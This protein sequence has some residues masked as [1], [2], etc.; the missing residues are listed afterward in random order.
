MWFWQNKK[1]DLPTLLTMMQAADEV[2]STERIEILKTELLELAQEAKTVIAK[3]DPSGKRVRVLDP[4]YCPDKGADKDEWF[5]VGDLH[6]DFRSLSRILLKIYLRPGIDPGRVKI[7]FLGDYID[8]GARPLEVLKLLLRL[9]VEWPDH[10]WLL[11][12]NHECLAVGADG[13]VRA[14]VEPHDTVDFWKE[15]FG[16]EVFKALAQLFDVLPTALV[17]PLRPPGRQN[18]LD[19]EKILY[20]HGGIPRTEYL[21][22]PLEAPECQ[23]G[24]LWSDPEL[25]KEDV[26]NGPRKRFSFARKD[27][28]KFMAHHHIAL[29]V[30]GHEWRK[31]GFDLHEEL[32]GA[33]HRI[34]TIF[35][36]GGR[37][38]EDS[39]YASDI[40]VPRFLSMQPVKLPNLPISV[41]EVYRDDLSVSGSLCYQDVK[42]FEQI[43]SGLESKLAEYGG[44][45]FNLS[46]PTLS[47][48]A[49]SEDASNKHD[50]GD[51]QVRL[52][53]KNNAP[54]DQFS[55]TVHINQYRDEDTIAMGADFDM[56]N[57][58]SSILDKVSKAYPI[59][60]K[61]PQ[62]Y[63][64]DR[65]EHDHA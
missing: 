11:K 3:Q 55:Y 63:F 12:G 19:V 45:T 38:N 31:D 5:V 52:I 9:K 17:Q 24:F 39:Y 59:F 6:G 65:K 33:E 27:F 48:M 4:L 47:G 37:D 20:V 10:F 51:F 60:G 46:R 7:I 56:K 42:L 49:I 22:L 2:P 41:E 23:G 28:L 14:T 44:V 26:L 58:I 36:C 54:A 29:L 8:R 30:R 25:E 16:E 62:R 57:A 15:Y 1:P 32:K 50:S 43:C 64:T 35:S 21:Q 18:V 13:I 34:I 40:I 53:L 61:L